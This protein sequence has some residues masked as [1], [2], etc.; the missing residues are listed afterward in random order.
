MFDQKQYHELCKNKRKWHLSG[1][2]INLGQVKD[3]RNCWDAINSVRAIADR[4]VGKI[5][6]QQW[7]YYFKELKPA[8]AS[9]MSELC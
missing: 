7:V 5:G 1:L 6:T 4:S 3:A 8:I 2:M 9:G